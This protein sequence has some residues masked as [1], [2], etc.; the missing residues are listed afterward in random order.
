MKDRVNMTGLL[1][2]GFFSSKGHWDEHLVIANANWRYGV[3]CVEK[4]AR[5]GGMA[6]RGSQNV[7]PHNP[8]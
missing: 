6:E 5:Q 1:A 3:G 7:S 8:Y 2:A 4:K